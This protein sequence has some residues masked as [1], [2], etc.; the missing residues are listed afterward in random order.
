MSKH[1]QRVQLRRK[2]GAVNSERTG[3]GAAIIDI[4]RRALQGGS[5]GYLITNQ[6]SEPERV[7]KILAQTQERRERCGTKE[8]V[9][10][11]RRAI[12]MLPESNPAQYKTLPSGQIIGHPKLMREVKREA[13]QSRLARR[14]RMR[15]GR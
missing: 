5:E 7:A 6:E 4:Y 12:P 10:R 3:Y 11:P 2:R 13:R 8:R 9:L 1:R 14:E 15:E